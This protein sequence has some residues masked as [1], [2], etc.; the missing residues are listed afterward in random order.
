MCRDKALYM[1]F[2]LVFFVLRGVRAQASVEYIFIVAFALMIIVPG[3]FVFS[4]YSSDS[5]AALRN[6]QI[7]KIGSDLITSSELMYSVGENSWQT[8]DLSIH[9]D[10]NTITIFSA[11]S[12]VSELVITYQDVADSDAVFFTEVPITNGSSTDTYEENCIN[13]CL[14]PFHEGKN[15]IR[16]QSL[17]NSLVALKVVK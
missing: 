13:G 16:I 1:P 12:G 9:S 10:I 14:I 11:P 15:S 2:L 4:Q 8:I 7:Y 5:Q 6:S 17:R 3:A